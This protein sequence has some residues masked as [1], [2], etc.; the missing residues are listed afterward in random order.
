V[1]G[2]QNGCLLYFLDVMIAKHHHHRRRPDDDDDD[3]NHHPMAVGKANEF[4]FRHW[5][6]RLSLLTVKLI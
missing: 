3:N 4:L 2:A 6:I 5:F 1:R